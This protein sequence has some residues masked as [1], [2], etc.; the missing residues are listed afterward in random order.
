MIGVLRSASARWAIILYY[1]DCA[2]S[3]LLIGCYRLL[4]DHSSC[5]PDCD[6]WL[7]IISSVS[8]LTGQRLPV[9][10]V[11]LGVAFFVSS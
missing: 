5:A 1:G 4:A 10:C 8:Y 7:A 9:F 11:Q 6:E 2:T 3:D